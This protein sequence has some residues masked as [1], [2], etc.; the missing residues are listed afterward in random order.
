MVKDLW[1]RKF[2]WL[3]RFANVEA[4]EQ[5]SVRWE[6]LISQI[7]L[8]INFNVTLRYLLDLFLQFS[9]GFDFSELDFYN[10]D[11]LGSAFPP[12]YTEEEKK[13]FRVQKARYDETYFDLSYL[14][15][16]NVTAQPLERALWDIRYKTTEKDAGFY[17]HV[18]ET[19]KKYFDIVKQQ[20]KDKKVLDDLLDAM[21]DI[22]AIVEGKIF[23]AIYVDLWV[24]GVSRVPEESEHGQVFSFRIPR[25]WVNED[26]A[27]TRYGY[28]HHVGLMRVGAFRALDFNIEF[29]DELIQP[30]VQRL[31]EALDFLSYIEQYGYEVLYPRT[32]MLQKLER[33]KHGGGDKQV[34]LQRIINDIKPILDKHGIIG[35]FRNAYLTFAKEIAFKDYSGHR[36]YKQYKKVLTDEDIINKYKSMGLQENILEEIKLKVKG[37]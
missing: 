22:L 8:S 28:E 27:E 21:E 5:A 14:D 26:K 1:Q 3:K 24:V 36:R 31:Q 25:D 18:G 19:V 17:K 6:S 33:Y 9:L 37:E 13:A 10:F 15:P 20:L 32:W 11:L 34:K 7:D 35:N 30:L 29:P 23:N 16:E 12:T 4:I 2:E